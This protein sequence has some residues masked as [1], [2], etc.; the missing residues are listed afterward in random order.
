M[1]KD[2]R[3]TIVLI[4]K[5]RVAFTLRWL[6]YSNSV[7]MPYKILIAD[8]GEDIRLEGLL[9]EKDRYPQLDYEYVRYPFDRTYAE[10]YRKMVDA[11]SRVET[12]FLALAD[13]DDFFIPDG[14]E[15]SIDFLASHPD[16]SSSSGVVAGISIRPD[17]RLGELSQVYGTEID[18]CET[19][20]P[21]GRTTDETAAERVQR[22]FR[23]HPSNW[24]DV[25]RSEQ[26]LEFF[27]VLSDLNPKDLILA[28]HIPMLLGY[29]AGKVQRGPFLY[30]VRQAAAPGSSSRTE[31]DRKGDNFDR[32][33]LESWS[34]DF[35]GFL[36]AIAEAISKKDGTD[37]NSARAAVK[38]GYRTF[39]GPAIAACF[40]DQSN[41][42][43]IRGFA[44]KLASGTGGFARFA[45]GVIA[46]LRFLHHPFK[47]SPHVPDY[48]RVRRISSLPSE[49]E[50]VITILRSPNL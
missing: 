12:P 42:P 6:R 24:Y 43:G 27:R 11:I 21:Y 16:Y 10:F 7:S 15:K 18:F 17:V 23:T 4:L 28:Q 50:P 41:A 30:L 33:L 47:K 14:L 49:M 38:Q 3:L 48:K 8:G 40:I 2:A 19:I 46:I 35:S 37:A 13:N 25:F 45:K 34:T 29:I 31:I 5:D 9:K 1:A 22:Q 20:Y 44:Q 26:A 36:R 39:M 32:M